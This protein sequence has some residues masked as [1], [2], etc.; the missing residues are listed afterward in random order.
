MQ[1]NQTTLSNYLGQRIY[2]ECILGKASALQFFSESS[3][4]VTLQKQI[5]YQFKNLD[6]LFQA[7]CHTSFVHEYDKEDLKSYERLEFLGDSILGHYIALN[8][9]NKFEHQKEG[10]LSRIK[11][12]LVNEDSLY[13]LGKMLNLPTI[14][15]LGKGELGA[16]PGKSLVSDV[17]ESLI[18]AV[19]LDSSALKAFDVL[20]H[21]ISLFEKQSSAVFFDENKINHFDSKS[22]FQELTMREFKC[23]PEYETQVLGDDFLVTVK[24]LGFELAQIQGHSKKQAMKDLAKICLDENLIEKIRIQNKN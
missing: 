12:T 2:D 20:D 3:E 22:L 9:F 24:V 8:L 6:I 18:A 13:D 17:F 21:V 23:L 15:L 1:S 16:S 19:S 5:N 14:I 10:V 4:I 11:N 7:F